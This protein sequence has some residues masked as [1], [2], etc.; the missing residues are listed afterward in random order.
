M[1]YAEFT[2]A[3]Y[4]SDSM[5]NITCDRYTI[6]FDTRVAVLLKHILIVNEE[7]CEI[8]GVVSQQHICCKEKGADCDVQNVLVSQW[9]TGV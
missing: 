9:R 4:M 3:D 8:K 7:L 2:D 5:A 1:T 6:T